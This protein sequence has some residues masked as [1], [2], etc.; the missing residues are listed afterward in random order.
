[1]T[2]IIIK[3]NVISIKW[4]REIVTIDLL[5]IIIYLFEVLDN[6]WFFYEDVYIIIKLSKFIMTHLLKINLNLSKNIW[7]Y[8]RIS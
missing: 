7:V 4:T 3:K 6:F 8:L 5:H 1:M 2:A